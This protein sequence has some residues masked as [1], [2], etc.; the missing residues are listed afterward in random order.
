MWRSLL[1]NNSPTE[2]FTII[3]HCSPAAL[4]C[5]SRALLYSFR[6][7]VSALAAHGMIFP[8]KPWSPLFLHIHAKW[9]VKNLDK[10]FSWNRKRRMPKTALSGQ[11]FLSEMSEKRLCNP[12]FRWLFSEMGSFGLRNRL[13]WWPKWCISWCEMGSFGCRNGLYCKPV[14]AIWFSVFV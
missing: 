5:V 13:Y 8:E 4:L 1:L 14:C 9:K 2:I 7:S 11:K 6:G 10:I 12:I 3:W